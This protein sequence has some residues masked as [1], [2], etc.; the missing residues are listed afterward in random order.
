MWVMSQH[1]FLSAVEDWD[2]PTVFKVRARDRK[3]LENM[4]QLLKDNG[5]NIDGLK[6][7]TGA[8]TDYRWRVVL[9]RDLFNTYLVAE[10][11]QIDYG[12]FK[13][14]VTKTRGKKFHDALMDVWVAMLKVDDGSAARGRPWDL[15]GRT[16]RR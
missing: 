8:G 14:Q 12:N 10:A 3:S 9:P 2:D 1:G 4:L 13:D 11:G 15:A 16:V 7:V 6:I 5:E